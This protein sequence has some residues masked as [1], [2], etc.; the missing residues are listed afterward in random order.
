MVVPTI[1][2]Q[3]RVCPRL[4]GERS[5]ANKQNQHCIVSMGSDELSISP[6]H[7][8][9]SIAGE[10]AGFLPG[11]G[12]ERGSLFR[13]NTQTGKGRQRG[14]LCQGRGRPRQRLRFAHTTRVFFV[15]WWR[16]CFSRT[17][18]YAISFRE[19]N[20]RRETPCTCMACAPG[21]ILLRW[22][23]TERG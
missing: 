21:S 8:L 7:T 12:V 15:A 20:K 3:E 2:Y 23:F 13:W 6:E 14:R 9:S 5:R 19:G 11:C 4:L 10:A 16:V 22:Q 17:P 1:P 18:P